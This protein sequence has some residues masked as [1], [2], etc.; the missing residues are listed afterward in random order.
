MSGSGAED[1]RAGGTRESRGAR[2]SC[3]ATKFPDVVRANLD[4]TFIPN[5]ELRRINSTILFGLL[6]IRALD[7]PNTPMLF[8]ALAAIALC[9]YDT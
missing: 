9:S 8:L 4:K 6:T 1:T 3:G 7:M 5:Y 2:E